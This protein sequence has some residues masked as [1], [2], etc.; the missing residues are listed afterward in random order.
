MIGR[1]VSAVL[2]EDGVETFQMGLEDD[3]RTRYGFGLNRFGLILPRVSYDASV[4]SANVVTHGHTPNEVRTWH[5]FTACKR[6]RSCKP[7]S[8]TSTGFRQ[9][10][11]FN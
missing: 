7:S 3:Y 9:T 6:G 5:A 4:T 1:V 10:S 8:G 11:C 2:I